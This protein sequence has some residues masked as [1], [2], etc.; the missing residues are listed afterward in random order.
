MSA[1]EMDRAAPVATLT[2]ARRCS[3]GLDAMTPDSGAV[4]SV[5]PG[6][7]VTA[8]DQKQRDA[9]AVGRPM[10]HPPHSL[11][12]L[13]ILCGLPRPGLST[14]YN[15]N[16]PCESASERNASLPSWDHAKPCASNRRIADAL[17]L[18]RCL[19]QIFDVDRKARLQSPS[20]FAGADSIQATRAWSGESATSR[21]S[22]SAESESEPAS[23]GGAAVS[24]RHASSTAAEK[25]MERNLTVV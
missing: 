7:R 23:S 21:N 5:G 24:R 17:G 3:T 14:T 6:M 13:P 16:W 20:A 4:A 2:I 18:S 12:N 10:R 11:R 25:K 19:A 15:C 9:L 8:F 1:G 22:C